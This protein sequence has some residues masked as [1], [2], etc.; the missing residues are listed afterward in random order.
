MNLAEAFLVLAQ[1]GCRLKAETGG[2][3]VLDV[4]PGRSPV[5]RQVLEV[6]ATHRESLAAVLAPNVPVSVAQNS[7]AAALPA[8][9]RPN[10][11]RWPG[12]INLGRPACPPAA[13]S[14]LPSGPPPSSTAPSETPPRRSPY[15]R[16]DPEEIMRR[17]RANRDHA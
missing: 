17:V 1:T 15:I 14:P 13:P 7:E 10:G 16:V 11:I 9:E 4:P 5:P 6:L 12:P 3:I 8:P 2:G